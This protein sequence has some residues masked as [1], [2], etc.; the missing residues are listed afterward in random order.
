[1]VGFPSAKERFDE[2]P[3]QLSGGMR[4]RVMI[5]MALACEPRLLIADEPTTAL[6]PTVGAQIMAL[7]ERLRGEIGMAILLITHDLGVIAGLADR[8][9][10]MYAGKIAEAG[11]AET[12]FFHHRHPYTRALLEAI[13]RLDEPT[14]SRLPTITGAPPDLSASLEHTCRFQ[15]RCP[16]AET[17]CGREEPALV[18]EEAGEHEVACFFPL[19]DPPSARTA[20]VRNG[21]AEVREVPTPG[22]A[23]DQSGIPAETLLRVNNL[24]KTYEVGGKLFALRQ[25]AVVEA[26]S[27]VSFEIAKGETLGL[28]GE[29][30]CGKSTTG[31]LVV[32]VESPTTGSVIFDGADITRSARGRGSWR[33]ELQ[34]VFQDPYSSLDPR[35]PVGEIIGEPLLIQ[36]AGGRS[37]RT[38]RVKELLDIVGLPAYAMGHYPYEFSGGQRQRIAVA[39]AFALSPKLIVA[40]EPVSALDVSIRAQIVNLMM[41]LQ[42][43]FNVSYLMISH[44]VAVIRHCSDRV[45]VMYLGKLVEIGPA[46]EVIGDPRHPYTDLLVKTVAVPDP[47]IERKKPRYLAPDDVPSATRP[48]PGCRFHPRCPRMQPICVQAEPGLTATEDMRK[49]ACHFPLPTTS[50]KFSLI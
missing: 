4:Q 36:N 27:S 49:V 1:L 26:V 30:G 18:R 16:R 38:R 19:R 33:R 3:H 10:V 22:L 34:M 50:R 40:D 41:D 29:S 48:P 39:R 47:L 14:G 45:A 24:V 5:A 23:D 17:R 11:S 9:V 32:A 20:A 8:I 6:D 28:I 2:Y 46:E 37:W 42:R 31:R 7:L 15:P 13:P 12:V 35:M 43:E 44:D 21:T 25:R